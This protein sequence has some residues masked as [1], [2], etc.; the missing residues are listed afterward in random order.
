MDIST[1]M[2]WEGGVDL[3]A[4]VAVPPP[5]PGP[6]IPGPALMPNVIVHLAR[7]VHTPVGSAPSGMILIP[8]FSDLDA[9]PQLVGFVSGDAH[10][11]A[12]FGTHI[13]AGTPF[14]FAPAY[15]G[16]IEVSTE[17]A[18]AHAK[19]TIEG[20]VVEVHMTLTG[21]I[22]Q[23]NRPAGAMPFSQQGLEREAV[24][25]QFL[26]DGDAKNIVVMQP[27]LTGG[28]GAVFSACGLYAR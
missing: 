18:A 1:W 2:S 27:A 4:T 8:D 7:M 20:M 22:H 5:I 3:M 28:Y 26:V 9:Q 25:V 10:V 17:A 13:F 19:V 15:V 11:A 12:Y 23:I 24:T 16:T 14:E 6:P 21:A